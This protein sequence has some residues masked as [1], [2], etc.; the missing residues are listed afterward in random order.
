MG[1]AERVTE[2]VRRFLE[3]AGAKRCGV[4]TDRQA[5][6][7][8][9]RRTAGRFGDTERKIE[10]AGVDVSRR[11]HE[12][13]LVDPSVYRSRLEH[14]PVE[15]HALERLCLIPISRFYRDRGIFDTLER[16]VLPML[17]QA[18]AERID[19]PFECW[20]AG[21]ASGEEPYTLAMLWRAR[22]EA[23]FSELRLRVLATDIDPA[24][25]ERAAAGC[26]RAS[27]LKELPPLLRDAAFERRG[28]FFCVRE[29]LRHGTE[30][31]R[32][33]IRTSM[34]DR[35]FDLILCRNFVL[36]YFEPA[37][38]R[39]LMARIVEALWPG[40]ALIVGSQESLPDV[41]PELERW[42]GARCTYRKLASPAPSRTPAG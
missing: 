2:L 36:T 12:L 13:G 41:L 5:K 3:C 37:L 22:F 16:D 35:R 40:G 8:D 28:E 33:D 27:S 10:A 20:S 29:S 19:A 17:A 32:Q 15:W 26:Y 18:A 9:Y 42:P 23:R 21:C 14:D 25:L 1:Q 31:V 34:P 39:A 30:F 38:Q 4:R 11:M 6:E 7:R 24:L